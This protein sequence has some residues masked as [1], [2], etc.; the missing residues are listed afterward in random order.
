MLILKNRLYTDG[1]N[2]TKHYMDIIGTTT[3]QKTMRTISIMQLGYG[4]SIDKHLIDRLG[5]SSSI[6]QYNKIVRDSCLYVSCTKTNKRSDNSYA[7]LN[8]GS[9]M[10]LFRFIVDLEDKNEVIIVRKIDKGNFVQNNLYSMF[11]KL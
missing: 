3:V 7:I 8:D 6:L 1:S 11:K 5:L 2:D 9:Y 10:Q 4:R